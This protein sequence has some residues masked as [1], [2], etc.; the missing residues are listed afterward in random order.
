MSLKEG[1]SHIVRGYKA[2]LNGLGSLG[3]KG[4]GKKN[5]QERIQ[6]R[7][8]IFIMIDKLIL[9]VLIHLQGKYFF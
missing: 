3:N 5:I 9:R 6:K 1:I 7:I 4:K 2:T 8:N